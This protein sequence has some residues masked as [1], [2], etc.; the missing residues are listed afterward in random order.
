M[1]S[2]LGHIRVEEDRQRQAM[3]FSR[4]LPG[5]LCKPALRKD[6]VAKLADGMDLAPKLRAGKPKWHCHLVLLP[7]PLIGM[8]DVH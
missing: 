7:E 5:Q 1:L 4:V 2:M 8:D 3:L 6:R